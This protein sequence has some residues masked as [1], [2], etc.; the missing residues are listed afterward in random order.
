CCSHPYPDE[1]V[2]AAASRR[3]KEEMGI[4]CDLQPSFTFI[5]KARFDNGLTEHEYDHVFFGIFSGEPVV[6]K[7]EVADWKYVPV[8]A[9]KKDLAENPAKYTPWFK[10]IMERG[11]WG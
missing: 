9:I 7:N 10:I 6:N 3:L 2:Q 4:E 5:Y 1:D 8:A 11:K